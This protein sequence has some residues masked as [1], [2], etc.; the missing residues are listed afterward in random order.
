MTRRRLM[1]VALALPMAA[2]AAQSLQGQQPAP[3]VVL[4]NGKIITVDERFTIA[5]AV[6]IK[7]DRIVAVGSNQDVSRL[8]GPNTR[9]IDLAGRAVTPGLIDNHMHLLRGGTTWQWEV[10]WDGV[11]S[12][13]QALELLLARAQVVK[14]G[15]WIFNLGGWAIEQFAD[16]KRPFTREE[17][18][19][20]VPGNPV[21]LQ[22]SYREAYLNSQAIQLMGIAD[23]KPGDAAIVR[24]AGGKPTGRVLEAGFRQLVNKLPTHSRAEVEVSTKQMIGDLNKAGLTAFG[25]AGCEADVL[26]IYQQ[27]SSE[28]KLNVRVFCITSPGGQGDQLL[29]RIPQMKLFQGDSYL[30]QTFYGES[31]YGP[32]HDPMFVRTTD[33]KPEQLAE[34]RRIATEIA[35]AR[36]PLH[37]HANLTNTISGFLDQIEEINKQYPIKNLRWTLAHINQINAT[38][39]E[40]MKKLGMYA[41]VHPWAVIN[42]GINHEVFGEAADDMAALRTIQSSGIMWGFGSDGTR[43]NQILPFT[44]IAWAVTG[45]MVGGAQVLRPA[46]TISREDALIAFTRRNAFFVFQE[47]NLGAIQPGKLADLTV[48]DRDYLTIPADQIKDIR[49]VMTMVGGR[50]VYDAAAHETA[51]KATR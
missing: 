31:V 29:A 25:S 38:H 40:R 23:S 36:L 46:Q 21:F 22:A 19:Q 45:K 32:L 28:G 18:D 47:D 34:W 33:P 6:A 12:R 50:V 37:V 15:E 27:W 30:D 1:F 13:K 14:P 20:V 10:R 49:P 24:D 48:L 41:A 42:G 51:G 2:A 11:G 8:A 26:P 16:D 39:L 43:A 9:R 4:S 44:T 3:D 17:L 7:G 35:K 5:Q